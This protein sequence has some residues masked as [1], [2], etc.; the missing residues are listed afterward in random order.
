MIISSCGNDV[1]EEEYKIGFSQAMTTDNWR[2]E[3][4]KAMRVESSMHPGLKLEIKDAGNHIAKQI[5]Q[6][7]EFIKEEVDV[8]IV[9]PI[10]SIPITPAIEKAMNAGIPV[11]IIDRKIEGRNFTAYVGADNMEIGRN[12]AKYIIS[13]SK[14]E[15]GII[16]ITGQEG[17]SPA[18]ERSIG[19][20]NT[21]DSVPGLKISHSIKGDWEKASIKDQLSTH[22]DSVEAPDYIFAHNDRM[23]MG[24]WEVARSKSLEDEISIIGV[25]GLFGPNGGIQMV[26]DGLLDAT[27][28]YPTG[29][30]EAIKLAEELLRGESVNKYNILRTVVID[31]VNVDIMQNQFDKLNQQQ[32]D[33]EQQQA[34]IDEQI[35]TYNTQS[36]LIKLMLVL[37]GLLLLLSIWAIYLVVKIKKSKRKLEIKNQKIITQRNQIEDFAEKLKISNESKINFF[38]ALSHEFKTPLTLIT[39]SIESISDKSK[40]ELKGI[41]YETNLIIN[42]SKRLLRLI[43]EL[44]DFRK[45]ESGSF[46]IKPARTKISAFLENIVNDFRAEAVKRSIKLDFCSENKELEVYIDRDM[47]DKVFFNILSNAF[48]FTPK[49]GNIKVS[50]QEDNEN[51][52]IIFRDSGIGIPKEEFK[53]IFDPYKQGSNNVKP[54]SGLGLFISKQ[55]VELHKGEISVSS[56]QGAEF[57]ISFPKGKAHFKDV[58]ILEI[59]ADFQPSNFHQLSDPVV[60]QEEPIN[61]DLDENAETVLII[62]DN[63]DLSYVLKKKLSTEYHVY[64]S[65][66]T[67]GIEKAFEIVPDVII[68]DLN[69]PGKTGFEICR[70]LKN[71]LR[72]SHIPTIILTALDDKESRLK[73]LKAGADTYITKP[74]NYEILRESLKSALYNREK[75]RYYYTNRIDEVRD[76]NFENAEQNFLKDLNAIIDENLRDPDFSVEELAGKL[77]IS[78]VQLYRKVKALLGVSIS[79]YISTQRLNKARNLLQQSDMNIS[80][81]AYEVGYSSPGYFSTSFKNKFGISPKQLKS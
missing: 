37:L 13:H 50:I 3:M 35:K 72:T 22:L 39:S 30:A 52:N 63:T 75:L 28:L 44:L 62:E 51:V 60:P 66:G 20:K 27:L 17:S 54:S 40:S 56:H 16:E 78:R 8:L 24:A 70:E 31:S 77:N 61:K 15:A 12:A 45:L 71:D 10:Q 14:G 58:E 42:N 26:K 1:S 47:V 25:D 9:S 67:D 2:R 76:E 41:S 33:I 59:D 69:L 5:T 32:N 65:D 18:Y 4:N 64:L 34:V 21:L 80:E 74:F 46:N 38:T 6:I 81:I 23:A 11:I 48:K 55:F 68:C 19:F 53:R 49:N 7:D 43:N 36:D 79:E 73:A 57:R 29:G